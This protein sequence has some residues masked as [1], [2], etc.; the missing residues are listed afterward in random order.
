MVRVALFVSSARLIVAILVLNCLGLAMGYMIVAWV[1][2]LLMGRVSIVDAF[3]GP[4]F[5]LIATLSHLLT[6]EEGWNRTES[7]LLAMVMIWGIRLGIYLTI[8]VLSER[9]EDRRYAEMRSKYEPGWWLKSLGI[10]FLLQAVIMWFVALPV[11]TAYASEQRP[12]MDWIGPLGIFL[13]GLGVFFE[14]VGDWQLAR[15]RANPGNKGQVLNSGLWAMTRH[16]NYFGDFAV[17]WGLWLFSFGCGAPLWTIVSPAAMSFFL[18]KVSGVT[19]LEKDI[20]QRRPGYDDY[21]RSTNAFFPGP[22]KKT[23]L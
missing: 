9:H 1:L 8:R 15:F 3:W 18:L 16:P 21:V 13:W 10:V 7:L 17:W 12:L 5:V 14:T 2:S 20:A 23:A 19:L 11:I 6:L 4:G 22:K